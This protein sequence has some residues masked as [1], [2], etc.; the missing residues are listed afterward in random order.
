VVDLDELQA[1]AAVG[2]G[3]LSQPWWPDPHLDGRD[4]YREEYARLSRPERYHIVHERADAWAAALGSVA[5][6][7]VERLPS[8]QLQTGGPVRHERGWLAAS[9]R[10]GTLPLLL[11]LRGVGAAPLAVLDIGVAR[12]DVLLE[13]LPDCGCDACDRGSDDLLAAVDRTVRTVVGGPLVLL[14]GPGWRAD[15][16]PGG[17]SSAGEGSGPDHERV[18]QWCRRLASGEDV[19]LPRGVEALV[20]GSWFA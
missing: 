16:H 17:G 1:R 9:T 12:R 8:A 11:L 4:S 2:Y 20:G 18:M 3:R 19:R 7:V 14:R 5:G 15:W 6:V 10:P 13:T